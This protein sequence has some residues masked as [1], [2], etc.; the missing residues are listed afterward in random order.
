MKPGA[1]IEFRG[2]WSPIPTNVPGM[3]VSE[4][5]P[6]QAKLADKFSVIR[7][8]QHGNG[9]HFAGG[10]YMLTGKGGV[11]Q[12]E[13]DLPEGTLVFADLAAAVEYILKS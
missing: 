7:S 2:I 12:A 6:L 8:I 13:G 3:Q 1:P 5:F 11:T 4:L 9:D 10:H